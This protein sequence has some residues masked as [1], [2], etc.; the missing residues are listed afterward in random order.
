MV[1]ALIEAFGP[2]TKLVVP[3]QSGDRSD[4]THWSN[5]PVPEHWLPLIR[6]SMPVFDPARVETRGMGRILEAFRSD[7][8][9]VRGPHPTVSFAAIGP[10]ASSIVTPASN[11]AGPTS[12]RSRRCYSPTGKPDRQHLIHWHLVSSWRAPS[13]LR[14]EP[15]KRVLFQPAS[16][17][18]NPSSERNRHSLVG[19]MRVQRCCILGLALLGARPCIWLSTELFGQE[20]F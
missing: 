5:R 15:H 13:P 12:P 11:S 2:S 1:D 16:R 20:R 10:Y 3:C 14:F 4:P 18:G 9:A 19:T 8:R 6:S 17:I 7:P